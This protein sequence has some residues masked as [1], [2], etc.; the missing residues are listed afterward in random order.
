MHLRLHRAALAAALTMTVATAAG[1]APGPGPA[2]TYIGEV[3][4][5]AFS[6][7]PQGWAPAN[8]ALMPISQNPTLFSLLGTTYGGNGTSTFALPDLRGRGPVGTSPDQAA[9]AVSG[10]PGGSPMRFLAMTWCI[11]VQATYPPKAAEAEHR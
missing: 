9:G 6:F 4:A 5:F 10:A 7:C 3:R 2:A 1:A 8:G 11:A